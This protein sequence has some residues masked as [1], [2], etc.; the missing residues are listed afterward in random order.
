MW[1]H[2]AITQ[3]VMVGLYVNIE[4]DATGS[5]ERAVNGPVHLHHPE[6]GLDHFAGFEMFEFE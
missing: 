4:A 1:T 3:Q 6:L 5:G 2:P